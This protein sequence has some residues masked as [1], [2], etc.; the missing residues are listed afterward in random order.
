VNVQIMPPIPF[1]GGKTRMA[2]T[3]AGLLPT[4]RHYV[5]PFAGSLAVLLAKEPSE[6]ETV[7]DLDGEVVNF[8]RV[9]RDQPDA[10]ATLC[11]YT[12][13]SLEEFHLAEPPYPRGLTDLERARRFFVHLTQGKMHTT[14]PRTGWRHTRGRMRLGRSFREDVERFYARI[15]EAAARIQDVQVEHRPGLDVIT[16]YGVDPDVLLYIDPPYLGETRSMGK[17]RPTD[18]HRY[19]LASTDDHGLMLMHILD[20]KAAVVL[21]AWRHPLYD[22]LLNI[23][24][25]VCQE[26]PQTS[27]I[28]GAGKPTCEVLWS[29][30]PLGGRQQLDLFEGT[31]A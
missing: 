2:P 29:N 3:I 26:F 21:S 25:W 23:K 27:A 5:E 20:A 24:P 31:T 12:P 14:R 9:V 19:D 6:V 16:H 17:D 10:L 15:E 28:G 8:W 13:H 11:E 4:H 7:N 1:Y 22:R 18:G 30:R